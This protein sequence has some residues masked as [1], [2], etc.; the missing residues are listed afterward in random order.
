[1]GG[2]HALGSDQ[3]GVA[4][5]TKVVGHA[6]LGS[7]AVQ[8]ATTGIDDPAEVAN[9]FKAHGIAQGIEDPFEAE[10]GDWRMFEWSHGR[11]IHRG[12]PDGHCSNSI[13]QPNLQLT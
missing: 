8:F 5:Y 13:E 7:S 2:A 3:A 11:I 1:M 9:D 10:I 4:Q 12:L 6:R